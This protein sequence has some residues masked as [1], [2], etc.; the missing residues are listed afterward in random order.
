MLLYSPLNTTSIKKKKHKWTLGQKD[1]TSFSCCSRTRVAR[2][3]LYAEDLRF[4]T[5]TYISFRLFFTGCSFHCSSLR[6]ASKTASQNAS[7]IG[8]LL[9]VKS[10]P[11]WQTQYKKQ[12]IYVRV[13][14]K[15][16]ICYV[17]GGMYTNLPRTNPVVTKPIGHRWD[18][19]AVLSPGILSSHLPEGCSLKYDVTADWGIWSPPSMFSD[20]QH[21]K[22]HQTDI[23]KYDDYKYISS[24]QEVTY[25]KYHK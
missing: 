13:N 17:A 15:V 10:Q 4:L 11:A 12:L 20:L 14:A 25:H 22:R 21:I 24:H 19:H 7:A 18:S 1:S 3:S 9:Q 6:W 23:L 5:R 8:F 16:S 2:A